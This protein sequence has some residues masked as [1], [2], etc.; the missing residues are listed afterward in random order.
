MYDC[1]I[2]GGGLA[3][4][5][6]AL[7][8]GKQG[9]K[10]VLFEKETYPFHKVCGEY[11]AL[12]SWPFLQDL[13]V[14]PNALQLPRIQRLL[15]SAGNTRLEQALKPGGYGISRYTLDALLAELCRK[16]G[17][18]LLENTPVKAVRF[19]GDHF[20]WETAQDHFESRMACGS[21]GKHANLDR[22]LRPEELPHRQR[23]PTYVGVK[24]HLK[25]R[26]FPL[27][28]IALHN[29]EG[30]YAGISAVEAGR[31]CF[32]YLVGSDTLKMAGGIE[33][34]E[35]Q[36]MSQNPYLQSILE[37]GT[38]L[39]ASPK[40]ISQVHF[41]PRSL[42]QD[43]VLLLGDASGMIPPLCGNGMSMALRASAFLGP[44]LVKTLKGHQSR[45]E[46]ENQYSQFWQAQFSL[47]LKAGRTLQ[48]IFGR[49]LPAQYFFKGLRHAPGLSRALIRATHGSPFE[50]APDRVH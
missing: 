28:L 43:H 4:L 42:I 40:T 36:I 25:L 10:V 44:E 32:C 7:Q 30:G 45:T 5:S 37:K 9:L 6:L 14:S 21:Y 39:Y 18:T 22:Q 1:G 38:S 27:D 49:V 19:Q 46:L 41:A 13:G 34:L 11:I 17:V 23:I 47:R 8:L 12:E 48:S 26:F 35:T 20:E 24:Y 31:V 3:G 50:C 15:V 16:V 2:V 29:F 33:G